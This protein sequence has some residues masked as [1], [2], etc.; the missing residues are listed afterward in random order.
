MASVQEMKDQLATDASQAKD[1]VQFALDM[2]DRVTNV[3]MFTIA[4]LGFVVGLVAIFGWGSIRRACEAKAEKL[5][6]QKIG[7]YIKSNEF[8]AKFRDVLSEALTQK[9]ENAVVV[10]QLTTIERPEGEVSPF[11]QKPDGRQP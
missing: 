3:S 2:L 4:I 5:A 6:N 7:D 8:D 9:W 1:Q 11:E 10:Q